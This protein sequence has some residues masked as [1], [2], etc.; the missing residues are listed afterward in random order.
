MAEEQPSA[1][2]VI[3]PIRLEVTV[4]RPIE[5]AFRQF[6]G[7]ISEWWPTQQYSFGPDRSPEVLMEPYAGGR[8]YERYKDGGEFTV[9]EVL[10]WEPP[11]RVVF[12]WHGVWDAATEVSVLFTPVEPSVTRVQLVHAGWERLGGIGQERRDQ[13]LN[14][15]PAVLAAFVESTAPH[16]IR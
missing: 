2:S 6:T 13:Y 9:G 12:T 8:F 3:E 11:R 16:S 5:E 4:R 7:R 14:G 1:T 15:W 10:R